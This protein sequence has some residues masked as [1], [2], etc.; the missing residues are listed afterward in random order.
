MMSKKRRFS[1]GTSRE[2]FRR[3]ST[4]EMTFLPRSVVVAFMAFAG[5]SHAANTPLDFAYRVTGAADV[6]PLMVFNDGVDTFIQPQDVS[7]KSIR[8]NGAQPT[9]QGPYFVVKGVASEI[10]LSQGKAPTVVITYVQKPKVAIPNVP[11]AVSDEKPV[12]TTNNSAGASRDEPTPSVVAAAQ[13]VLAARNG[14]S[15]SASTDT[16]GALQGGSAGAKTKPDVCEPHKE[17]RDSALVVTFKSNTATLSAN[18]KSQIKAFVRNPSD[19]T[20]VEIIS[21][22]GTTTSASALKR[23]D[24]IKNALVEAGIVRSKIQVVSREPTGIGA[25]IYLH[26]T[27]EIPCGASIV[28]GS[29]RRAPLT[30]IWDGDARNLVERLAKELRVPLSVEGT[31]H[32][33]PVRMAMI[34]V[35]FADAMARIGR[36]LDVDADLVLRPQ[37]MILKYKEKKQ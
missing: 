28:K 22:G 5:M 18:A 31:A 27:L 16:Q 29:S 14:A 6:R 15:K 30:V 3:I 8:V 36:A 33:V 19:V 23:G 37:E 10:T 9:R 7:D 32:P 12:S 13:S 26:R 24:A 1:T 2:L 35:P 11:V 4:M 20:E 21:E 17:F 25:E 34:S